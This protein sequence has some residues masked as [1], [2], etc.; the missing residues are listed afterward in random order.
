[1]CR[2]V[3]VYTCKAREDNGQASDCDCDEVNEI[4]VGHDCRVCKFCKFE[5][6]QKEE[7]EDQPEEPG[8]SLSTEHPFECH[9]ICTCNISICR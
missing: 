9:E 5:A 8:M 6:K 1:M 3:I 7:E 2:D 4:E